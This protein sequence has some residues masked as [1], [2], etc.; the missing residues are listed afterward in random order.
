MCSFYLKFSSRTAY[1]PIV[2]ADLGCLESTRESKTRCGT[3]D[4]T[5]I[6]IAHFRKACDNHGMKHN[7]CFIQES[8]GLLCSLPMCNTLFFFSYFN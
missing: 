6:H 5:E 2:L 7:H 1:F 8:L 3:D 4:V